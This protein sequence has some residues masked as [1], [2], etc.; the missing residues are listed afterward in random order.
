M[1][2]SGFCFKDDSPDSKGVTTPECL[3]ESIVLFHYHFLGLPMLRGLCSSRSM[4][5]M[6]SPMVTMPTRGCMTMRK[7]SVDASLVLPQFADGRWRKPKLS[8]RKIALIRKEC[9]GEGILVYQAIQSLNL[10]LQRLVWSGLILDPGRWT[11]AAAPI[12]RWTSS[13][14]ISGSERKMS[15]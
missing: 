4:G 2:R 13:R 10:L 14:A 1:L 12:A 8:G 11:K 5:S 6:L 15:A 7:P 3:H 9:R